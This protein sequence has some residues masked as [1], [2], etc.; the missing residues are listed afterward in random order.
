MMIV[1]FQPV[2]YSSVHNV[3]KLLLCRL[4]FTTG[5]LVLF[6]AFNYVVHCV[7]FLLEKSAQ[8]NRQNVVLKFFFKKSI[9][10][11]VVFV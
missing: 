10:P 8:C 6:Y 2:D 3:V 4:H 11:F 1:S 7:L 9:T 5:S